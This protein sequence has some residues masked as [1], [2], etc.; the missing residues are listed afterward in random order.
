MEIKGKQDL[1]TL[2]KLSKTNWKI[3]TI[4]NN[5]RSD[6][7][8]HPILT[9]SSN[10]VQITTIIGIDTQLPVLDTITYKS[11]SELKLQN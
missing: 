6:K 9:H 4:D 11:K 5:N 1:Q 10:Y 3:L 7:V 2:F 8:T